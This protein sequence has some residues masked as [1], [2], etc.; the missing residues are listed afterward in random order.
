MV[1]V[2]NPLQKAWGVIWFACPDGLTVIVN[3]SGSPLQVTPALE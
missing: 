2:N 1:L 3:S